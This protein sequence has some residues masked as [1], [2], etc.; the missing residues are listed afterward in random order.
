MNVLKWFMIVLLIPAL[1]ACNQEEIPGEGSITKIKSTTG[2]GKFDFTVQV[3]NIPE[4]GLHR[5][6]LSLA[7]DAMSLY[8]GEFIASANVSDVQTIYVFSLPP[9]EYYWQAGITCTSTGDTCLWGGF[10]GGRYGTLWTL[11]TIDIELD[12]TTLQKICFQ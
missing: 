4:S 9:G 3:K 10:P 11:G 7:K 5:I 8:R 1:L 2:R 6:D 12:K